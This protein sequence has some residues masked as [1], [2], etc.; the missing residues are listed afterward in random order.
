MGGASTP[1]PL[2]WVAERSKRAAASAP[3]LTGTSTPRFAG[4][5]PGNQNK[6]CTCNRPVNG[7][8]NPK[9]GRPY[10]TCCWGCATGKP[11][12][13][14]CDRRN[15]VQHTFVAGPP[16]V[17]EGTVH[18]P[19]TKKSSSSNTIVIVVVIILALL[20]AAAFAWYFF[21]YRKKEKKEDY[22]RQDDADEIESKV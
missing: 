2:P 1:L 7:K 3:S 19:K 15:G 11:H 13:V 16:V 9:T 6:T 14:D 18:R 20:L 8:I 22:K 21:F 4:P 12:T 10:S 5:A 17:V